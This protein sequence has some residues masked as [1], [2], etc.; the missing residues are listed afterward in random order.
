[1]LRLAGL[2]MGLAGACSLSHQPNDLM[3]YHR[4]CCLLRS[5]QLSFGD[6]TRLNEGRIPTN[7][8]VS[9]LQLVGQTWSHEPS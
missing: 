2:A 4:H 8:F 7:P 5:L 1:M 9:L 6:V 3:M